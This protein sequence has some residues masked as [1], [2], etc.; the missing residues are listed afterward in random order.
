MC[1]AATYQNVCYQR[2]VELAS[3]VNANELGCFYISARAAEGTL[4]VLSGFVLFNTLHETVT[5]AGNNWRY[6]MSVH[7]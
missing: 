4:A 3:I 7:S 5:V 2:M 6:C 1:S